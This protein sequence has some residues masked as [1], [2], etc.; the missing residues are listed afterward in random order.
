VNANAEDY[1][2][3]GNRWRWV[4]LALIPG[5][6]SDLMFGGWILSN[7]A[8]SD[9]IVALGTGLLYGGGLLPLAAPFYL[10]ELG[11]RYVRAV[12]GGYQSVTPFVLMYCAG[13]FVLWICG[14]LGVL[15]AIGYR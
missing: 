4:F 8:R 2:R 11:R 9:A 10:A 3:N 1:P 7:S 12:H 6:L 13:N 14:V 5:L 15:S